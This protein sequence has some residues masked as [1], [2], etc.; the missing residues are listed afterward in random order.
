MKKILLTIAICSASYATFAQK[1]A[2]ADINA[3][4]GVM[5]E[6]EKVNEDLKI[7]AT[8]LQKGLD[9]IRAQQEL[10]AKK[11]QQAL[12]K[13]DTATA[14]GIQEKAIEGD[15]QLQE[16]TAKAEQQLQQKRGEMMQPALTRIR[17]AMETISKRDGYTYVLNS[18]DGAGTSVV[19]YGPEENNITMKLVDELG[20]KLE[21][22]QDAA[23]AP[24]SAPSEPKD[25]KKK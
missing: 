19:L 23:P 5:P 10:Y 7:Y 25:P 12:A 24:A 4:I 13:K 3:I 18:I 1:I 9:D 17:T 14:V 16:A 6:N 8:G 11:F 21:G 15:K 2:Y 20:I 22:R